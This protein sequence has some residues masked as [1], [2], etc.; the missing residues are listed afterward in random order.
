MKYI[1]SET[2]QGSI[3]SPD[4]WNVNYDGILREDMPE[5]NFLVGY[6]NDFADVITAKNTEEIQQKLRRVV[7]RMKTRLNSHS[8]DRSS[9]L[10]ACEYDYW[11]WGN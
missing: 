11:K 3:L 5:G 6:T 9:Y 1:T 4:L 2:A 8:L 7:L 10:L